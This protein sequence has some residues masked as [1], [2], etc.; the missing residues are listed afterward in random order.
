MKRLTYRELSTIDSFDDRFDY[1]RL[2]GLVGVETFGSARYLNQGFYTSNE[3]KSI[4]NHVILR[5]EGCDLGVPGRLIHGRIIVHHLNPITELELVHGEDS[6]LDPDNLIC[7]SFITHQ[8]I[9]YGD[10]SLLYPDPVERHPNDTCP[11]KGG[12]LWRTTA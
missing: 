9:H 11:W 10:K 6:L 12:R 5:D 8:A 3:W 1:L 2:T 4:R 7:V